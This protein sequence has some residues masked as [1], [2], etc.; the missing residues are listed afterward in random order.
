MLLSILRVLGL[1]LC[2]VV[3]FG[4]DWRRGRRVFKIGVFQDRLVIL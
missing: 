3:A 1:L 2:R 4:E